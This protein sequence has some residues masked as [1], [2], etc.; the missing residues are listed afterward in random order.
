M[1]VKRFAP[2]RI[3][4]T[5]SQARTRAR[6]FRAGHDLEERLVWVLG[7]PRSGSTWLLQLLGE[8]EAV[9]PVNEPLI[10]WF[11]G[12]FLSDLPGWDTSTLDTANFTLRRV[13]RDKRDQFFA[14]QF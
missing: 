13:Q 4:R 9:V 2:P 3:R 11:L 7:S 5:A 6:E 14:T 10:G 12:P 1:D 8:H